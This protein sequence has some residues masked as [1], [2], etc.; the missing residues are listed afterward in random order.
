MPSALIPPSLAAPWLAQADTPPV[1]PRLPL[2]LGETGPQIGSVEP[3]LADALIDLRLPL[4][5]IGERL[6]VPCLPA[7]V[8]GHAPA[9]V[10]A[11]APAPAP[12]PDS[13][14]AAPLAGESSQSLNALALGLRQLGAAGAWRNEQLPVV[15][16]DALEAHV[17]VALASIERAAVRPLGL[18]THAV[19]LVGATPDGR[20][21]VQQRALDKSTDPGMWDTLMG[22]LMAAGESAELTLQR[23]AWEE[24]GLTSADL[25]EVQWCGA[26]TVWRPLENSGYMIERIRVARVVLAEG[27]IPENQDGEVAQ[28]EALRTDDLLRRIEAGQFTLEAAL[29]WW[30]VLGGG[31]AG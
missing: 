23:E 16:M 10:L 6:W 2:H 25:A 31:T 27:R 1:V 9:H 11:R 22:G 14:I 28:F 19:H 26:F 7:P 17:P 15:A 30:Q 24:A 13:S 29:V 5:R 18:A 8:S 12:V 4:H 3:A 21:W 20:W